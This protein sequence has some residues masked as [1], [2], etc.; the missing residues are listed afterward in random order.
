MDNRR[1]GLEFATDMSV[2]G[3]IFRRFRPTASA[4]GFGVPQLHPACNKNAFSMKRNILSF[5][6]ATGAMVEL[7]INRDLLCD[8]PAEWPSST[9]HLH[10]E[11]RNTTDHQ[12][13][14]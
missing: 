8:Q 9:V 11:L 7:L 12:S 4:N 6:T 13:V 14:H 10:A 1:A 5:P 3:E 2:V